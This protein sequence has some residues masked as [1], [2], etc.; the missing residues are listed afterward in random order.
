MN[1]SSRRIWTEYAA[2]MR[3]R[4]KIK[5]LASKPGGKDH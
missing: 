4:Q 5:A 3:E 2:C 1:K